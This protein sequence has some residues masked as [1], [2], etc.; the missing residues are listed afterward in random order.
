MSVLLSVENSQIGL[1]TLL[2][3]LAML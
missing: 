1:Q 3:E 2:K